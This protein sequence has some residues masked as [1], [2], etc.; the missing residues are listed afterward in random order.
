MPLLPEG[1]PHLAN[2]AAATP[3][4]VRGRGAATVLLVLTL[5]LAACGGADVDGADGREQTGETGPGDPV[6]QPP[7]LSNG[8][9]GVV[10]RAIQ[11]AAEA[12]GVAPADVTVLLAEDVVWRDGALGC[13]EEGLG[14]TQAL[15]EGYRVVLEVDGEERHYHGAAGGAPFHCE[16]PEEPAD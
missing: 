12:T 8:L 3:R 11:D 16:D 13:P 1:N 5:L 6:E 10:E 4:R 9:D 14:Y 2:V 15:V 7:E